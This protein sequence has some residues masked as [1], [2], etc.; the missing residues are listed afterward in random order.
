MTRF[1]LALVVL[2]G[3]PCAAMAEVPREIGQ[4]ELRRMVATGQ[5]LSLSRVI[6][7]ATRTTAG[8]PVDVRLFDSDGLYYRIVVVQPSGRLFRLVMDART[9]EILP[10]NL[11]IAAR[12]R[13]AATNGKTSARTAAEAAGKAYAKGGQGNSEAA[14]GHGNAGGNGSANESG[15]G[16]GNGNGNSGGNGNGKN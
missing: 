2:L 16:N 13:A 6:D 15:S 8:E 3:L 11:P 10:S 9:G 7:V 5:S 1:I 14:G 4:A 12:V